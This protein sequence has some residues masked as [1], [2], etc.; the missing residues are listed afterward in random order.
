MEDESQIVSETHLFKMYGLPTAWRGSGALH[1]S[2]AQTTSGVG[3]NTVH[4]F[5][6]EAVTCLSRGWMNA[7]EDAWLVLQ[8]WIFPWGSALTLD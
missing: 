6:T 8:E 2:E 1:E 7:K 4:P 5:E 3:N